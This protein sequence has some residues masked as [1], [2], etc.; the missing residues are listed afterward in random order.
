MQHGTLSGYRNS[1]CRC[2]LCRAANSAYYRKWRKDKAEAFAKG[3]AQPAKHGTYSTYADYRCRC[4]PC[5]A[6]N[7]TKQRDAYRRK[8]PV[9]HVKKPPKPL[10][11]MPFLTT[12]ESEI[13]DHLAG[14][15]GLR[16]ATHKTAI[17][18]REAVRTLH[19]GGM[20]YG[21][22]ALALNHKGVPT[23]RS[24]RWHTSRVQRIANL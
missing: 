23:P 11:P 14:L 17:E 12:A 21:K 4:E 20:S 7:N 6:A 13:L 3:E 16:R 22:I 1:N 9:V 5:T 10:G 2:D 19:S 15:P 24:Q 8:H 18:I